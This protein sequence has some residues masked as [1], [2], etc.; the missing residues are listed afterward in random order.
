M[1]KA[2]IRSTKRAAAASGG[3]LPPVLGPKEPLQGHVG[4]SAS[5][6]RSVCPVACALDIFG[7]RWTLL[8]VRDLMFGAERFK[9]FSASPERIPTNVLTDRLNRLVKHGVIE[10]VSAS[11]GTRHPAYRLTDKGRDMLPVLGAM[12]D[13][14]LKWEAGTRAMLG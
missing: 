1:A 11:D 2:P 7:D 9:Q 4:G 5:D 13:W 10:K 8:V 14:G 6:R 3:V 12:R